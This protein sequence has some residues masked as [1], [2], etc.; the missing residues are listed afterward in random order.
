MG[1][2]A[3]GPVVDPEPVERDVPAEQVVE[4][5]VQLQIRRPG[6]G[7]VGSPVRRRQADDAA[8]AI[9][10]LRAGGVEGVGQHHRFAA[11]RVADEADATAVERLPAAGVGGQAVEHRQHQ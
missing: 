9:A 8:D 4:R 2:F 1:P 3:P 10:E 5:A 7:D 6:Q 11:H